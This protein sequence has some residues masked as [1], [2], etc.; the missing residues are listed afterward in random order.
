MYSLSFYYNNCFFLPTYIKYLHNS[1]SDTSLPLR[2]HSLLKLNFV[3][4]LGAAVF[5]LCPKVGTLVSVLELASGTGWLL[6]QTPS[7]Q[8]PNHA[9]SGS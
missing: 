4:A 6:L 8:L 2:I 1:S 3:S 5:I 9:S 7:N